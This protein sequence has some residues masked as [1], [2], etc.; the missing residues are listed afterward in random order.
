MSEKLID[1]A[2]DWIEL[3]ARYLRVIAKLI[4]SALVLA[5]SVGAV[6][7]LYRLGI[8]VWAS[9]PKWLKWIM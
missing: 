1:K 2:D 5:L 4:L 3:A 7:A 9:T 8:N 6:Y